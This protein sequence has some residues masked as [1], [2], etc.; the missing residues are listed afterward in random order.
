[1]LK[2]FAFLVVIFG[3]QAAI[4]Y[5]RYDLHPPVPED[6]LVLGSGLDINYFKGSFDYIEWPDA[7]NASVH[8]D[9]D[10][11]AYNIISKVQNIESIKDLFEAVVVP[12]HTVTEARLVCAVN[13][14]S[15][16]IEPAIARPSVTPGQVQGAKAGFDNMF[17]GCAMTVAINLVWPSTGMMNEFTGEFLVTYLNCGT[18][19]ENGPTSIN[20]KTGS[21]TF[22]PTASPTPSPTMSP[23]VKSLAT[24][25]N[26]FS[27]I[28]LAMVS[29]IFVALI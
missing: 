13:V 20:G 9:M 12:C 3:C 14:T 21:G 17:K 28:A 2:L 24:V 5:G 6:C 26:Q 10:P 8:F 27:M 22:P 1:M 25:Q 29:S 18:C 16:I 4:E 15:D 23:T 7:S 19:T 11:S